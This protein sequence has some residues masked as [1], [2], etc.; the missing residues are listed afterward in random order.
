[1]GECRGS[2]VLL[3]LNDEWK[4]VQY[5]LTVPIPNDMLAD[6]ARDIRARQSEK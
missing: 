4:I 3:R 2:G 6:V 5:N 1:Y